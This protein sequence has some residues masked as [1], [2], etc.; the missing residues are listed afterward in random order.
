MARG[1]VARGPVARGQ[2]TRG[3]LCGKKSQEAKRPRDQESES[4]VLMTYTNGGMGVKK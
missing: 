1:Q 2:L 3:P 4:F